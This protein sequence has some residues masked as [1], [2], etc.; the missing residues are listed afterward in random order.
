MH[1]VRPNRQEGSWKPGIEISFTKKCSQKLPINDWWFTNLLK[2][3]ILWGVMTAPKKEH[4]TDFLSPCFAT[5]LFNPILNNLIGNYLNFSIKCEKFDKVHRIF[6]QNS[7]KHTKFTKPQKG[8][9]LSS[10]NHVNC[11]ML[12]FSDPYTIVILLTDGYILCVLSTD[13]SI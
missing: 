8:R 5:S 6:N 12:V 11:L 7:G 1:L 10:P 9:S 2:V 4:P 13:L 3:V